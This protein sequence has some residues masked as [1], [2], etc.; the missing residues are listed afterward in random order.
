V[1][2]DGS[3]GTSS[4]NITGLPTGTTGIAATN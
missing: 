4:A 3:L 1:A 2:S